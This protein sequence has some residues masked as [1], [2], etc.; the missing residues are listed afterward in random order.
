VASVGEAR[1]EV[2]QDDDMS[3]RTGT[4]WQLELAFA[5]ELADRAR[6]I[7]RRWFRRRIAVERKPDESPVTAA[8]REIEAV[9]IEQVRARYPAH[10]ILGEE[11]GHHA[12][13]ELTWVI[14]PIDGTKSF[15]TGM[16][17]FGTLIALTRAGV[18]VVGVIEMPALGERWLAPRTG[19]C[20]FNG[21]AARVSD[22]ARLE[23][24]AVYCTSPD[25]FTPE[26]WKRYDAVSRQA[27]LRRFGG[28]CYAYGL[29]ASG[30]CDLVIES[31]LKPY[32]YC[33][34]VPVVEAAGG[35]M[36]D[37]EGRPLTLASDGN[38]I[39]A[40]SRALLEQAV[41]ALQSA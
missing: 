9:L 11:T 4:D 13:S 23:D 19:A 15:I 30:H 24:A 35:A 12:G 28:D 22:C 6:A 20:D 31:D 37:W 7:A 14:D 39:A 3:S 21:A 27:R 32:D 29:L 2:N 10:A 5:E 17:T 8:D 1:V 36:S 18:P 40:A 38:V 16:P 41:A 25:M 26:R 33:A 34:L